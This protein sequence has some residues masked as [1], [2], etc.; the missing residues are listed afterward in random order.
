M[1][2]FLFT[3]FIINALIA[4]S[5]QD[6]NPDSIST[7]L[8]EVVVT[9]DTQVETAQ[10]V[11]LRPTKLEKEHSTN[12]YALL[13]N[14]NLPDF[15]VNVSAKSV[16][17]A[18][19]RDVRLLINGVE[20]DPDELATLAASDIVRIDCQRNPG[21]RYVGSG[22]VMNFITV[23]YDY[24]GNVYLSAD[25]GFARQYGNYIGMVNYKKNA[26]TMSLTANAKWDRISQL[27]SADNVYMLD[28]GILNQSVTPVEGKT[29]TNSQY[30]NLKLA[31]ATAN[32]SFDLSL[33][34]TRS[35]TPCNFSLENVSYT[36]LY[37]FSTETN[38]RSCERGLSPVLKMHYNL[39]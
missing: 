32:H 13:E 38:R 25:E 5:Q 31:H 11:I 14:M 12:G 2:K 16:S 17:T 18:S 24:G 8:D 37:E 35:A 19:G 30:V 39:F 23:Q 9:A 10:K 4:Y 26:L 34:L 27:N 7:S 3:V 21:G 6:I 33:A 1:K 36:G 15:N 28:D 29:R 22:A 20:V